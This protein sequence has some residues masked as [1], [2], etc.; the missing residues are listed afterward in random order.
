MH[1]YILRRVIMSVPT[2][3]GVTVL[4]FLAMRVLPGDP[5]A[6]LGGEG[7]GPVLSAQQVEAARKALG[8]DR[9]LH[10][11][12]VEWIGNVL[13][14]DLGKSFSGD[15]PVATI[16]MARAPISAQIALEA[17]VLSWLIGLPLGIF[18]ARSLNTRRDYVARFIMTLFM[19][20]PSFWLGLLM[21]LFMMS[22]FTWR[23]PLTLAYLTQDP[24]TNLQITTGPALA[25]GIGLGCVMARVTRSAMLEDLRS[26]YVRTARSKGV[27]E[28]VVIW[29]HVLKN[30]LLP[31]ITVSGLA[32]GGLIGGAVAV[33]T[34]FSV[35]GTG[36]ALV[37]ALAQR[38]WMVIQNLVLIYGV[39]FVAINLLIDVAYAVV[40]PRIRYR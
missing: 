10:I 17:I 28:S 16:V 29:G 35:P 13:R 22:F 32:F 8:I 30:A 27:S 20:V 4:I 33:E 39:A 40:D 37:T 26:D 36:L 21:I 12:Y 1:T 19:A 9:P 3:F 7:G 24:L 15:T 5:A 11:Q 31:I 18:S 34:A 2:I 25:L 23:P 14:G 6:M 38:D